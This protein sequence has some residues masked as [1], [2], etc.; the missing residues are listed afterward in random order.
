MIP[1][2]ATDKQHCL[3]IARAAL[4]HA[5]DPTVA[6]PSPTTFSLQTLP[7][8]VSLHSRP[9][10]LRGCIGRVVTTDSLYDNIRYLARAAAFDDP[11]FHAVRRDE[12]AQLQLE[13]SILGPL[14]PVTDWKNIV[15]G[16]HGLKVS[17]RGR[18]GLLLAQVATE[19]GW[20]VEKFREETCVKA[21][22]DPRYHETYQFY[23][24]E[25][26]EF[27]EPR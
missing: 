11:R 19:Q 7:C 6:I 20:D 24:F 13:I 3:A 22:L 1:P 21:G 14:K 9:H 12:V 8:F 27:H 2:T 26:V 25:Q 5:F 18:Q 15:I 4:E 17:G 10:R 23:F 16:T